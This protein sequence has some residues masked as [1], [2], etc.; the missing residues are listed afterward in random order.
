MVE[1]SQKFQE[2]INA[3]RP[4]GAFNYVVIRF[5]NVAGLPQGDNR[6]T[7]NADFLM[8]L[9][10]LWMDTIQTLMERK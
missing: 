4:L 2:A 6:I 5:G 3:Q 1:E 8:S 7:L 9:L 10:A